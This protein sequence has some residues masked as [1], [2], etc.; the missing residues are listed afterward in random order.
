[1]IL[2]LPIQNFIMLGYNPSVATKDFDYISDIKNFD[3][4]LFDFSGFIM[5]GSYEV[6]FRFHDI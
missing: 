4:P 5:L 1:M 6:Q 3:L 2:I